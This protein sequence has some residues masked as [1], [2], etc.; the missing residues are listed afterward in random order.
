M[1]WLTHFGT[2]ALPQ[3]DVQY[4]NGPAPVLTATAA[5]IGGGTYDGY[6]TGIARQRYPY[7]LRY[8]C[9]VVGVCTPSCGAPRR[10]ARLAN[11][12]GR[13]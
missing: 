12:P 6:G 4:N 2:V 3:Y 10:A 5:L 1:H 7:N 13:G 8:G 9:S 11:G